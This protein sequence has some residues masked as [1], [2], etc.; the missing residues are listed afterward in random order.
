[1]GPDNVSEPC[2]STDA[3]GAVFVEMRHDMLVELASRANA[4]LTAA[5]QLGKPI[6]IDT[7]PAL[8]DDIAEAVCPGL[9]RPFKTPNSNVATAHGRERA[10]MTRYSLRDLVHEIQL[11]RQAL[12]SA[13][14][15]RGVR[16]G[17]HEGEIIGRAIEAATLESISSYSLASAQINETF[18]ASLSHDLRNP[19]H[20]ANAAAQLLQ[21]KTSDPDLAGLARRVCEKIHEAD[22]MIQTLLDAAVLK[23][24]MKLELSLSRFDIMHLAAEVCAD[25]P[26]LGKPITVCGESIVGYWCKTSMK[27]AL[28]NLL[29][30]AQKY[31]DREKGVTVRVQ[32]LEERM[33]M[34]VH[35]DGP[36]IPAQEIDRLFQAFERMGSATIKG[37]GLGLPFVQNVAESHGGSVLADS[38]VA[39]G[40]TFTVSVPID[41]RP[42]IDG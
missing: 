16:V 41:A 34:S 20:V 12:F 39:R 10:K 2:A 38:G 30:N 18:V 13:M 36:P 33:L 42:Y 11:F 4:A 3:L 6:L 15:T 31:G 22:A 24:R 27:R 21:L 25:M 17:Q 29:S 1:M 37:W 19:L 5:P 26:L 14:R 35:N 9:P 7:L 32:R 8:Y 28:E 23:E 40:T